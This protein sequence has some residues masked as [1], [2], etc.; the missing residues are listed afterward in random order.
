[1]K[2][3]GVKSILFIQ[4]SLTI[5][6]K[7]LYNLCSR[8]HTLSLDPRRSGFCSSRH[9]H[10]Q[11]YLLIFKSLQRTFN[12]LLSRLNLLLMPHIVPA[13]ANETISEETILSFTVTLPG[14]LSQQKRSETLYSAQ[15]VRDVFSICCSSLNYQRLEAGGYIFRSFQFFVF[16]VE[17]VLCKEVVCFFHSSKTNASTRLDFYNS[18]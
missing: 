17:P 3:V 6:L 7:G 16:T 15:T 10:E 18:K 9:L 12:W 14:L 11:Y 13:P 1:M 4:A 8:R 2:C 5:C